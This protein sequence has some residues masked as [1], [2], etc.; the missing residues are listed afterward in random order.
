MQPWDWPNHLLRY[1]VPAGLTNSTHSFTWETNQIS[2]QAL[3]GSYSPAPASTNLVKNWVFNNAADVPQTGDENIRI[4][5]WLINS[6][7]PT[8][9]Q[10]VEFIVKSFQFVPLAPPLPA[11]LLQP[12][13]RNGC[14]SFDLLGQADRRYEVQIST[15][16]STWQ[17]LDVILAT[18]DLMSFTATRE[19]GGG[20]GFYRVLTLP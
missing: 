15:N 11:I 16:L 10:E 18:N 2:Y 6:N 3:R 19:V 17:S 14:L 9:S 13:C 12:G 5:L 8:D 4:N 7:P 1:T 20:L